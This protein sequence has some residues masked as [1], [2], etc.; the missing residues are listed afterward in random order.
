[1]I[2]AAGRMG[3]T[4][5]ACIEQSA[6]VAVCCGTEAPGN[7]CVGSDVGELAGIGSKG[8]AVL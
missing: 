4:I 6:G 7:S 2:G 3:R 5:I 1:M 8:I